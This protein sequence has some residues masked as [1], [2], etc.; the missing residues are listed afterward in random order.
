MTIHLPSDLELSIEAVVHSGQFASVDEAMA[1][2]AR[3]LLHDLRQGDTAPALGNVN[4]LGP[5]PILGCMRDDAELMD[6]I[7][8]DTY[9]QRRDESWRDIDL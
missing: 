1:E 2:A 9:R 7:V 6:E 4:D 5:D 3:R 8:A